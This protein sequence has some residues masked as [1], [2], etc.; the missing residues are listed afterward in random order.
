[1]KVLAWFEPERVTHVE[2]L[3]RNYGYRKEWAI[4]NGGRVYTNNLGD[5]DCLAWTLGRITKMMGENGVDLFREDNN[6]DPATAWPALDGQEEVRYGTP[7]CGMAEN[8]A[9]QGHYELWDRIIAFCAENGKCTYIDNCASGGG[10]NDIDRT[11]TALRL[12]MTSTFNRWIPFCGANT[13]ESVNELEAG[14]AGGSSF[15]VTRASWLPVY[16]MTEVWTHDVDLDYDRVRATYYE[17]QRFRHLLLKDF[18][19]LS[20]WHAIQDDSGWTVFAWHDRDKD[21]TLIQAFRQ[22]TCPDEE[23]VVHLP[24]LQQ[25]RNYRVEDL[26]CG[27]ISKADRAIEGD[28]S[29]E[30]SVANEVSGAAL[31]EE[32]LAIR[33]SGPKQSRIYHLLPL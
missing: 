4:F 17:W 28:A 19:V 8:K 33:L 23:F 12:S 15:Y 16:N 2:D 32:G 20:P 10:R 31:S 30:I 22:E 6:S 11:T 14:A 26:G 5:P 27:E 21:E 3:V 18:Y 7:R 1:M 25:T 29:R 24:F 9:V 13:K